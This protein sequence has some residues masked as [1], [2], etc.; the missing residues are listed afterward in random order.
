MDIEL[1]ATDSKVSD[2]AYWEKHF[3]GKG[4]DLAAITSEFQGWQPNF[5][6]NDAGLEQDILD[7]ARSSGASKV[8]IFPLSQAAL[9][10]RVVDRRVSSLFGAVLVEPFERL[11]II[12]VNDA[13]GHAFGQLVSNGRGPRV[14]LRVFHYASLGL[15]LWIDAIVKSW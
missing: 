10:Q 14:M 5:A 8:R 4:A 15:R 2:V 3:P 9:A 12:E 13:I 7:A 11:H 6:P 1:W